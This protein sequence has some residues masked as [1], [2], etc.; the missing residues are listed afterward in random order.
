MGVEERINFYD[1]EELVAQITGKN[2]GVGVSQ[3]TFSVLMGS[4]MTDFFTP[5][6]N[7]GLTHFW[8]PIAL[9][10]STTSLASLNIPSGTAP[11]SPAEGDMYYDGTHLYFKPSG[12]AVDLL[13]AASG[14]M[15]YPGAGV[16]I[17][18]GSAWGTSLTVGTGASNLVQLDGSGKLP[19]VDGS[20]LTGLFDPAAPGAIGGTTPAAATFTTLSAGATG[21]SVDADGDVTAKSLSITRVTG[22]AS[23]SEYFEVPANGDNKVTVKSADNLAA[24]YTVTLPSATGTL[25]LAGAEVDL[26]S[27]DADPDT[28]GEIRHD[29][30]ITGLLRGALKWFDGTGARILVDLDTAPSD[31]DYVVSYDA[32]E[33]KFYM[34]ADA[35]GAGGDQLVDI[36]TT[37]PLL[38]NGGTNVDNA[39]PGSD[40]D[41]TF[42]V[43]DAST[44]Q[45]GVAQF[46]SDN[47]AA[48]NG[49]ITVKDDGIAAAEIADLY[50]FEL[51]PIAWAAD[52]TSAPDALNDT[53]RKP[54]KYRTFASDT[55]ED[56]NFIWQIP[57]DA[58]VGASVNNFWFRVHY[59]IVNATG[60]SSTEGVAFS[61]AAASMGDNDATNAAKGSAVTVKDDELNASQWDYMVTD[62][63]SA[64]T[65]T[66]A[67][68]G[69]MAELNLERTTADAVDDYG[70][71]VGVA[72]IE[73]R[74][75]KNPT[76]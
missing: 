57:S 33:D 47:F 37:A 45:K 1:S 34:K 71:D 56:V 28:T 64:V 51:I 38:V 13:A 17:S 35:T 53:G 60:P 32:D 74:Y 73:I 40:A 12:D 29:S 4:T 5:C 27:S 75:V 36:V 22:Q 15:V 23:Y 65:I 10:A 25:Q 52:G 49:T 76:R 20:L 55:D 24:D 19:A 54:W 58:D 68:A 39:L 50:G 67:A 61:L 30:T 62:W 48:S 9:P 7:C 63:S 11:S 31:D 6:G 70:Q 66:N 18:T 44:S 3:L 8:K 43:Q 69:E 14:E 16:P 41:I 72:F 21:F 26:P 46:S 2:D 42:S 59:L